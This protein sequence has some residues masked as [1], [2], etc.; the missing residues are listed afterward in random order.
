MKR[1]MTH[2][3]EAPGGGGCHGLREPGREADAGFGVVWGGFLGTGSASVVHI[4]CQHHK[5]AFSSAHPDAEQRNQA[6]VGLK[7]IKKQSDSSSQPSN[8]TQMFLDQ[9]QLRITQESV[10]SLSF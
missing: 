8:L 9:L 7:N 3:T 1:L 10:G 4:S 5:G 2:S 6:E